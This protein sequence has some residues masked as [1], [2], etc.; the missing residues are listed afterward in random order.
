VVARE[1]AQAV[2]KSGLLEILES[3]ESLESIGGL[4]VLKDWLLKRR[5][6]FTQR[7]VDYG[8]PPAKGVLI[9]GLP[10]TGKSLSAKVAAR[11]FGVPLLKLDAGRLYGGLVG[12]SE[13]NLR[14]VI[15]TA[16]AIAP[17]C[18]W[19][20]E[21][22]KGLA[23][24]KSSGST[25]GGTSARVLG[26]LLSW[27][28]EKTAP[29]FVVATAND[30]TQLPPE[31][32]RAGRWDQLFFVDLP[33]LEERKE[34]W[35]IQVAKRRRDPKDFDVVQLA[36]ASE[37][38]TGSE[39]EAVFVGAMFDAF[40]RGV[41]PTDFDIAR[42]LTDFVPLSRT[43]AEQISALRSWAVG[44]ARFATTPQANSK[45]RKLAA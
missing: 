28:Q 5:H 19:L 4:D 34:I 43:M 38:L 15:Q 3:R 21:L 39:I 8:L 7:A 30:V 31:L 18:L 32:L 22:E 13:A 23:G 10:G 16:E 6:A 11:V 17:C 24:S 9:I 40:D 35:T 45:L 1:K 42:T 26:S 33:N 36:R 29:V 14:S 2:K 37:G 44:R 20:D 12:Q 27:M 41:E 25:D